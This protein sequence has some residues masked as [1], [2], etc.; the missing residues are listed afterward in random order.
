[1]FIFLWCKYMIYQIYLIDAET[2]S[3]IMH[4]ELNRND[5]PVDDYFNAI[6]SLIDD[7]RINL[8]NNHLDMN[9]SRFLMLYNNTIL[10][11]YHA[12]AKIFL[13]LLP[14]LDDMKK[15]LISLLQTLSR[16][17]WKK[18]AYNIEEYRISK[19]SRI[20][21]PFLI[22]IKLM[23]MKGSFGV[24]LPKLQINTRSLERL[25]Q[26]ET[27]SQ[28]EKQ[29]AEYCNGKNTPLQISKKLGFNY[30]KVNLS[31]KNLKDLQIIEEIT[32]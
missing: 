5:N 22:E 25:H 13:A 31:L 26:M 11:T 14:D 3:L 21:N 24:V 17:F 2:R 27:L 30:E 4:Y 9:F 15:R 19:N 6:E 32:H 28:E 18:Y 12:K 8:Q 20:F 29:I 10:I 1:M 23:A 16:R 7:I